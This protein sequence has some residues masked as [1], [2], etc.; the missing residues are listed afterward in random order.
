MTNS[1]ISDTRTVSIV[2]GN[3]TAIPITVPVGKWLLFAVINM[4][5]GVG[6]YAGFSFEPTQVIYS[7][8][9]SVT[10]ATNSLIN[11]GNNAIAYENNITTGSVTV[12][13][14][15]WSLNS[16]TSTFKFFGIKL[17]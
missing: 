10:G 7:I 5:Q 2:G 4:P 11:L 1:I 8:G 6:G 12:N 14:N 3:I 13:F 17:P 16:F 15:V 9:G